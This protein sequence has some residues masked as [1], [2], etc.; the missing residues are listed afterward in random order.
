VKDKNQ[1]AIEDAQVAIYKSDKSAEYMNEQ[2][3]SNGKAEESFNYPGSD[4]NIIIRV[5]KSN[6]ADP[7][8]YLPIDTSGI[9]SASGF[10]LSVIM[11][12]DQ[13]VP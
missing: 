2:T 7:P 13:N 10:T 5:R 9:I 8:R 4:V 1:I 3:D 6:P 12:E 11:Q